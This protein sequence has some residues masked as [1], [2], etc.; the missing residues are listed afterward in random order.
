MTFCYCS[1]HRLIYTCTHRCLDAATRC[2]VR[3]RKVYCSRELHEGFSNM[4][5]ALLFL[6]AFMGCDITPAVYRKGQISGF[7]EPQ[8]DRDMQKVVEIFKDFKRVTGFCCI[9][10]RAIHRS[11][12]TEVNLQMDL[13]KTRY[14][15]NTRPLL[16]TPNYVMNLACL[17]S[18]SAAERQKSLRVYLQIRAWKGSVFSAKDWGWIFEKGYYTHVTST[19][20]PA[21]ATNCTSFVVGA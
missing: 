14:K 8:N 9:C 18:T 2:R 15:E 3:V 5:K 17:Y 16:K 12:Y 4:T 10:R 20:N 19:L 21:A 1:W 7:K 6:H 13:R 11:F